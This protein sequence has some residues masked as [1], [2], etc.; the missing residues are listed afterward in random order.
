MTENQAAEQRKNTKKRVIKLGAMA[1]L[2][3]VVVIFATIAWFAMNEN[4]GANSMAVR[5]GNQGFEL[6]VSGSGNIAYSDLYSYIDD[7][8]YGQ[9]TL[10]TTNATA[11]GHTIRW[12]V[13]GDDGDVIRPGSKGALEFKI[14]TDDPNIPGNIKFSLDVRAFVAETSMADSY[15]EDSSRSQ[16]Q[17]VTDLDE[18][19]SLSDDSNAKEAADCLGSHLMFFTGHTGS[20][21]T[22]RF[23]G[24]ISDP[25]DFTLTATSDGEGG[26]DAVIYWIWPNTFGQLALEPTDTA[27]IKPGVTVVLD[28]TG[29]TNDR[30]AVTAYLIANASSVFKG[31]ANVSAKLGSLYDKKE[32]GESYNEEYSA[33]STGYNAADTAIGANI[34]YALVL[35]TAQLRS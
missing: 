31:T 29:E 17:V 6:S 12:R 10:D 16:I 33:L 3:L 23:H 11:T 13:S 35:L 15:D 24:F 25:S 5:A 32:A 8:A 22:E 19:T 21:A 18:I 28:S 14:L 26:Y 20:G 30:S 7:N 34:D 4:V 1:V 9:T 2:L 27:H